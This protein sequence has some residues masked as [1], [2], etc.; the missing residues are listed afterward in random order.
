ME[1]SRKWLQ[2]ME[3]ILAAMLIIMAFAML[4]EKGRNNLHKISVIIQ[5]SDDCQWSAFRYGLKMAA[6]DQEIE[7]VIASTGDVMTVE[8]ELDTIKREIDHGADAVIVQPVPGA[9]LEKKLKKLE[10]KVPIMLV[11]C[12]A[13]MEQEESLFPIVEPDHDAMGRALAEELLKD[14]NG[15]LSGKTVG[16]VTE[17]DETESVRNRIKGFEEILKDTGAECSWTLSDCYA[18]TSENSLEAQPEVDL[19]IALDDH[20]LIMTAEYASENNLH[21]ALVYGIG[22]STEA[23]YYLDTGTVE[24]LVVPDEFSVGYQSLTEAAE[25]L[26]HYFRKMKS[27][28]VSH[29]VIHRE[30]LFKRENQEILFTMSQ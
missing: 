26:G 29:T 9:D 27:R 24:C 11:E 30:E 1:N 13:A 4:W 10:K 17:S 5:N 25:S 22:N 14:Y 6:Q 7:I 12:T 8:E 28:T 20:S 2:T 16:I 3:A 15:N 19:V 23:A 18:E 21:G